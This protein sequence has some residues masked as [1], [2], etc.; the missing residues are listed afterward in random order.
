MLLTY[1]GVGASL[2]VMNPR[3]EMQTVPKSEFFVPATAKLRFVAIE[4]IKKERTF[5]KWRKILLD[6]AQDTMPVPDL[7]QNFR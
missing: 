7:S 3:R 2:L 6:N 4:G 5:A 1:R